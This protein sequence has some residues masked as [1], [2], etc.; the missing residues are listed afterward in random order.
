MT[1][2]GAPL[3]LGAHGVWARST[4]ITPELAASCE[5]W[6]YGAIWIGGSPGG[7]LAVVEAVLDATE[8]IVVAPGVVNMW[9]DPAKA[10]AGVFRRL[11]ARHPGRFLLGVGIGHP[12]STSEYR[13]PYDTMVEYL[14]TLA[15]EDVPT[16]RIVLAALGPRALRLS[17][18]KTA[19]AHP[20][21][22]TPV[23][24]RFA[25]EAI[26]VDALLAPEQTVVMNPDPTQGR[27]LARSFV[28]R[29][30]GL[31]NYTSN[32]HREGWTE[33]DLADGG[34]EPLVDALV[35][36]GDA[37]S[38]AAGIGAHIAAGADHVPIQVLDEDKGRAFGLLAGA[39]S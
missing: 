21:L 1:S 3:D 29:Y 12:E 16:K 14:D 27:A 35:L 37:E 36:R 15:A 23:H 18:Q 13:K 4:E 9:R 7:D 10:I 19:G 11:E 34:S 5:E 20:Y 32:L 38:I 6:G 33:S 17:G 22:T 30:L 24:T 31:V 8:R 26:G 39:F 2:D 25:R 28:T